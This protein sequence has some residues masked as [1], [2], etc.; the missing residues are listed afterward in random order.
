[1]KFRNKFLLSSHKFVT[2]KFKYKHSSI[3]HGT[4]KLKMQNTFE[5]HLPTDLELNFK[6][7]L[8]FG[9]V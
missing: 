7:V 5:S 2:S 6:H 4:A 1:M 8:D 9:K 3:L